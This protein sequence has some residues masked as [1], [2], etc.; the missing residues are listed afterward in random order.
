M[1]RILVQQTFFLIILDIII[2]LE[3]PDKTI[4]AEVELITLNTGFHAVRFL[5]TVSGIYTCQLCVKNKI[6]SLKRNNL[7]F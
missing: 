2:R 7:N 6:I 4:I 5:P 3:G 1:V